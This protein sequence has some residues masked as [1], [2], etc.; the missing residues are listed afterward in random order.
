VK[1]KKREGSD[2]FYTAGKRVT[3]WELDQPFSDVNHYDPKSKA[4]RY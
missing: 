2:G 4:S 3:G 1:K